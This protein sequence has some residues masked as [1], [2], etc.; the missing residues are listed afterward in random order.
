MR[1]VQR[2]FRNK[3]P[4][5]AAIDLA[6]RTAEAC[7]RSRQDIVCFRKYSLGCAVLLLKDYLRAEARKQRR[8]PDLETLTVEQTVG[9]PEDW[10]GAK[11]EKRTL[12]RALRRLPLPHQLLIE[13]RYWEQLSDRD[14]AEVLGWPTGT[15]KTRIKAGV[16]RL[17]VEMAKLDASPEQ[18]RSTMDS[19]E[20]WASRTHRRVADESRPRAASA[21][22]LAQGSGSIAIPRAARP[23]QGF[24]AVPIAIDDEG[25]AFDGAA[26]VALEPR[27]EGDDVPSKIAGPL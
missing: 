22:E 26:A 18:I 5:S 12:L 14:V 20:Q 17:R 15:V 23:S 16:A 25:P 7:V 3:V 9:T 24:D 10:V 2:F 21:A 4:W 13:L 8:Q 11:Q 6:Q 27:D 19:L 1:S